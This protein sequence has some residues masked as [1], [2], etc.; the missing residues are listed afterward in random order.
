MSLTLRHINKRYGSVQVLSDVDFQADAGMAT[1][2]L[3]ANGAG[4]ST[5]LKILTGAEPP[6]SGQI[7]L[8]GHAITF[9][10]P[11]AARRH[12]VVLVHQ[13]LMLIPELDAVR[14]ITLPTLQTNLG[15]IR[16]RAGRQQALSALRSVGYHGPLNEPVAQLSVGQQQLIE[17]AKG[18]NA[19][20]RYLALDEPTSA[21]SPAEVT[22]LFDVVRSLK[23]SGV[24]VIFISHRLDEV[25]AIS[26][27]IVVV[28]NGIV[29][30]E[31]AGPTLGAL[32]QHQLV[33]DM[34][35]ADSARERSRHVAQNASS[36]NTTARLAVT[37]VRP[38]RMPEA[39]SLRVARSEIVGIFGLVGAGRT[40]LLRAIFG[41]DRRA[42]GR[43]IVD[44]QEVKRTPAALISHGVAFLPEDRKAQGLLLDRSISDNLALPFLGL[45]SI[46]INR[47]RLGSMAA[48]ALDRV[49]VIKPP[50][51]P[52][53]SLSGGNQQKVLIARWLVK[54]FG[55]YLFDEPT[56]GIDISTKFEIYELL[57]SLADAGASI[58]FVSSEADEIL[59]L[60]D[61]CLIMH[62][63][64][65]VRRLPDMAGLSPQA[66]VAMAS[67]AE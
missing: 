30:A 64:R 61:R 16:R 40:E 38:D 4:K 51:T 26:D 23:A 65:I 41:L 10:S 35:G 58:L 13:E 27:H 66:L 7:L 2:I 6:T 29:S 25:L 1:S 48:P 18:I 53:R 43:V 62:E 34:M 44:G 9:P 12:G 36:P 60:A 14:N 49:N 55:V 37:E 22:H 50:H 11:G 20:A 57:T 28:R 33:L 8:D 31:Y 17:I 67:R 15:V 59:R 54:P 3:G 45:K 63:G 32:T 39:I 56:R 52:T 5:L 42:T 47:R 24:A 21:L 46:V 19:H